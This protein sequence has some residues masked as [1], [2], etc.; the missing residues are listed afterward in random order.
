MTT[1]LAAA[2]ANG[3]LNALCRNSSYA[4]AAI[5]IQL[6]VDDPGDDGTS[7]LAEEDTRKALTFGDAASGGSIATT[8]AAEWT[9]V[10]DDETYSHASFWTASSAG[11]FL[12]SAALTTPKTVNA[13]D[14]FTFP[15]GN[16]TLSFTPIAAD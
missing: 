6:H 3:F 4:A 8:A 13:G 5:Y 2:T 10:A 7:D 14:N 1:G 9:N 15:V 12:G 11:T 16:I